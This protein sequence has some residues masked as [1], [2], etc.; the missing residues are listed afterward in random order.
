MNS[1]FSKDSSG[2]AIV[3][4]SLRASHKPRMSTSIGA[5]LAVDDMLMDR[6]HEESE[7]KNMEAVLVP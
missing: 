3:S 1:L 6:R 7:M 4:A 5:D 2:G